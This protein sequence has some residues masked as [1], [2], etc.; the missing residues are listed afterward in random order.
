LNED[1]PKGLL[2]GLFGGW[3]RTRE[4]ALADIGL[5]FVPIAGTAADVQDA[6]R[7]IE[8]RDLVGLGLA[9]VGFVP[10]VGDVVKGVGKGLRRA[11]GDLPAP[12]LNRQNWE[13][14]RGNMDHITAKEEGYVPTEYIADLQGARGEIRGQ[15]RNRQGQKWED[16]KSDIAQRGIQNPIF[17]VNEP[18]FGPRIYEGNHRLDA[19]LEL[20]L[21]EVPVEIRHFGRQEERGYIEDLFRARNKLDRE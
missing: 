20:G 14:R 19:A 8:N 10:G 15:H 1:D 17:I 3:N 13:G 9:G 4:N 16:F 6:K 11:L 7:A 12:R 21:S 2:K 18:G 5:G